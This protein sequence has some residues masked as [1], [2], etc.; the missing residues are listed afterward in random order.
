MHQDNA[1]IVNRGWEAMLEVL[2]KEMPEKKKRRKGFFFFL[3]GLGA[4]ATIA[5]FAFILN[6]NSVGENIAISDNG[7]VKTSE[8]DIN[9][10]DLATNSSKSTQLN[11]TD[12]GGAKQIY[13][14][15]ESKD[16]LKTRL[17]TETAKRISDSNQSINIKKNS[18]SNSNENKQYTNTIQ[19]N[20]IEVLTNKDVTDNSTKSTL[21]QS[22]AQSLNTINTTETSTLSTIDS[23]PALDSPENISTS[24]PKANNPNVIAVD[25]G[26]N[27]DT[28]LQTQNSSPTTNSP[29]S[30]LAINNNDRRIAVQNQATLK[31]ITLDPDL[32]TAESISKYPS[33]TN[34]FISIQRLALLKSFLDAEFEPLAMT[35]PFVKVVKTEAKLDPILVS[36]LTIGMQGT[37]LTN[38]DGF[39]FEGFI[40]YS[41]QLAPYFSIEYRMGY[42]QLR[43]TDSNVD[44][45]EA[46]GIPLSSE[47]TASEPPPPIETADPAGP[48]GA[49]PP[50]TD[51]GG[52]GSMSGEPEE[53]EFMF[54]PDALQKLST[55]NLSKLNVLTNGIYAHWHAS[56]RFGLSVFGGL[57]YV[58]N[59]S[60]RSLFI[61]DNAFL[62]NTLSEDNRTQNQFESVELSINNEWK[63]NTG[64][65][66]VFRISPALSISAGYKHYLS[67]LINQEVEKNIN[68]ARIGLSYRF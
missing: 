36:G 15:I 32:K 37:Y 51:G 9:N 43:F 3:T 34:E 60:I 50:E 6:Q 67:N 10:T 30:N 52:T 17:N 11:K 16:D 40:G 62:V 39:G 19:N 41:K 42:G 63:F 13:N 48:T 18:T 54:D 38:S 8:A 55:S 64:M 31:D 25:D 66:L 65:D 46:I 57:D 14:G 56:R 22:N 35:L 68:Q 27:N 58:H 49:A 26:L 2:D 29:K 4:I 7:I 61:V 53:P 28:A 5:L 21:N 12:K 44:P 20:T 24:Q 45:N 1:D 33:V 47:D 59:P 23:T